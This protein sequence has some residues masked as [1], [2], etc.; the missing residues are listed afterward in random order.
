[1]LRPAQQSSEALVATVHGVR[2]VLE[3]ANACSFTDRLFFL[4]LELEVCTMTSCLPA[5]FQA[6]S[7]QEDC[8]KTLEDSQQAFARFWQN[9]PRQ[10]AAEIFLY[11]CS[12]CDAIPVLVGGGLYGKE[13]ISAGNIVM[14]IALLTRR[15]G[16]TGNLDEMIDVSGKVFLGREDFAMYL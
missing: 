6:A 3:Q 2:S 4:H 16:W 10:G 5:S 13:F 9:N 15:G 11:W 1:M 12:G 8:I 14:L 7:G